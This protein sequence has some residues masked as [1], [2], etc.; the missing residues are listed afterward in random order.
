M[1]GIAG[2]L[3]RDIAPCERVLRSMGE[4][5]FQRGPDEEGVFLDGNLG[6]VHRRLSIVDLE[7]GR[8]PIFNEDGTVCAMLNGEIYNHKELRGQLKSKGHIFKTES[9]TEVLVHLYEEYGRDLV[10]RLNGMFVF[11]IYDSKLRS[12]MILRDRMGQ[13]PLYFSHK[14]SMFAFASDIRCFEELPDF[15]L[16]IDNQ[17][18]QYM[19]RY[20]YIP[21]PLSIYEEI[22]KL[23]P[24]TGLEYRDGKL[25][26]WQYWKFP[27]PSEPLTHTSYDA[28]REEF[29][30]LLCDSVR[31]RMMADVPVGS[32]LSGGLDS[33]AITCA[34]SDISERTRTFSV[35][36]S[37]S[38]Y[39]ESGDAREV[40]DILNTEHTEFNLDEIPHDEIGE[41]L[42]EFGEPFA[43]ASA[44]PTYFLC[45]MAGTQVK[46]ALSG[47]GAD[48]LMGG[49]NRYRVGRL[50]NLWKEVPSAIR[51]GNLSSLVDWMPENDEYYAT[52]I[53]KKVKHSLRL[54]DVLSDGSGRASS[55]VISDNQLSR[56]FSYGPEFDKRDP[57]Y[58]RDQLFKTVDLPERMFYADCNSYLPDDILVKVDRMSMAHS[59]EVRSPFMD[60]RLVEFLSKVPMQ[61]K[62][63]KGESKII[64]RD[65][66]KQRFPAASRR[67][68]HGFEA[69]IAKWLSGPLY[70]KYMDLLSSSTDTFIKTDYI[71]RLCME[72]ANTRKDHSKVLWP[73]YVLLNWKADT[74]R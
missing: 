19:L 64:L 28:L 31:L 32:F 1:C 33:T 53:T 40:A 13:K 44:I 37:A 16:S 24:A 12:L 66:V 62:L 10:K 6:M 50:I 72:H 61:Y 59:L 48:E 71:R 70:E 35:G 11:V 45:K 65:Y 38:T 60:Y 68:K 58:G 5:M 46:V 8:N 51:P 63:H 47:D 23:P 39:D 34:M 25:E 52:N 42:K 36:F 27:L 18:E 17:A 55:R 67:S 26:R 69:P 20:Q 21:A 4:R 54:V 57:V 73:I 9:D 3:S 49:Y 41:I 29:N 15:S 56:V 7:N 74:A 30:A 22:E 14:K 2:Y 43:D